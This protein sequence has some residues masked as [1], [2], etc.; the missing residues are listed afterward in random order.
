[1]AMT[2]GI[3][4][5]VHT[6]IPNNGAATKYPLK[7]YVYYKSSQNKETNQSTLGVGM[8]FVTPSNY[9]VGPWTDY[10][11][12]YVGTESL[13]FN[14]SIPNMS[15]TRWLAEDKTFIVSHDNE[16]K[17]KATIKW[18]WGVRSTWGG[19]YEESGSFTVDLPTIPRSSSL[20]ATDAN[21]GSKSSIV[22]TK[23]SSAYT[24]SIKYEFGGLS[25]YITSEGG[26]STSE[27]KFSNTSISF[28]VPASFYAQIPNS[29]TGKCKLICTTYSG[30]TKIGDSKTTE[31]VVT[32][33]ESLCRPEVSGIAIDS[34]SQTVNLTGNE[35][36][37]VKYF[38]DISCT[39]SA[40][41]L[42]SATIVTKKIGG[43]EVSGTSRTIFDTETDSVEFQ[44]IDS[45]GYSNSITLKR[46]MVNYVKLTV[47]AQLNRTDPTSGNATLTV[48]GNYFNSSFGK[49]TN[50]LEMWYRVARSGESYGSWVQITPNIEKNTYSLSISLS[51]LDYLYSYSLEVRAED[52]LISKNVSVAIGPGIPVVDWGE[53]DFRFNV[54]FL[55][56]DSA[57][58]STLPSTGKKGQVFFLR[59][60]DGSYSIRIHDGT[61]W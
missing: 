10:A 46:T 34:S 60:S 12:S 25:G 53:K 51:G 29:K 1:M 3:A 19:F 14:G 56:S 11:G 57:R 17:A 37:L 2:G 42:N 24:H 33:P 47:N 23:N 32:A 31:F 9:D 59:N 5:L 28:T 20:G 49:V 36:I 22:V 27:V 26:V 4:K 18:K 7:L 6:G 41:A 43:V 15:G 58:G 40:K 54:P 61:S 30:N 35:N 50:T 16:G 13:T 48:K 21:I 45:R 8:Y 38:S 39:I 44:A 52:K 55:I